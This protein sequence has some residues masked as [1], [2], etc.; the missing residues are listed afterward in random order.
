MHAVGRYL[1]GLRDAKHLTQTEAAALIG[2]NSKTIERWEAGS[3][4]PKLSQLAAYVLALDGSLDEVI[5]RLVGTSI[6]EEALSLAALL[7]RLPAEQQRL[8]ADVAQALLGTEPR[9]T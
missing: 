7:A 4:E 6:D 2:A 5:T 3:H 1:R 9:H 8:L